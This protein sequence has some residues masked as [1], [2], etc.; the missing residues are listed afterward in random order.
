MR[1]DT[2]LPLEIPLGDG[3]GVP[4]ALAVNPD[5]VERGV[6]DALKVLVAQN[7]GNDD[8]EI[9]EDTVALREAQP[10]ELGEDAVVRED[11]GLPV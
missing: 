1:E 6:V 9:Q 11:E 3:F 8:A 4:L 10:E 2:R 5:P 7:E